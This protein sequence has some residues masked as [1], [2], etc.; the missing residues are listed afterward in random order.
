LTLL[1]PDLK[2]VV[3]GFK[4]EPVLSGSEMAKVELAWI[5]AIGSHGLVPRDHDPVW[6]TLSLHV[7]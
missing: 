1:F 3:E 7:F 2:T 4:L 5:N 6:W